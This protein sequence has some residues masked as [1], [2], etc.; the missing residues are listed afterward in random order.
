ME[1]RWQKV[2]TIV[3]LTGFFV[4]VGMSQALCAEKGPIKIGYISPTTGNFAQFG[5][6]MYDGFT[7]F[8]DEIKYQVAGRKIEL[9]REE[10]GTPATAVTKARKLITSDKINILAGVWLTPSAYAVAPVVEEAGIPF[11]VTSSGGDDLTQR[12]RSDT[13]I[14]LTYT[15]CHL[16]HALGHF[17][18]HKLGWRT[19]VVVGFDYAFAHE[20]VGAFHEVFEDQGGKILQKIWTPTD[21]MDFNPYVQSLNPEADGILDGVF[22]SSS[23]RFLRALKVAGK[24]Q[25]THQIAAAGTAVDETLLPALGDL[26][27]GIYSSYNWSAALQTPQNNKFVERTHEFLKREAS[28]G[29]SSNYTGADWI[30]RAIKAVDGDVENKSK[31]MKTLKA[32]EIED[33]PRG[34]VRLGKYNHNIQN[35]YIRRVDRRADVDPVIK[36]PGNFQETQNTVVYTYPSVSQFWTYDPEK[37]MARPIYSRDNPPCKFC[38]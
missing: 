12:K 15:G 28:V 18:Y 27:L 32:I 20:V 4:A 8:L 35:I 25:K 33:S 7:M 38:K 19:A 36:V 2:F 3:F 6:D 11:V 31:F 16:G 21:T 13:L 24:Y 17:A 1:I 30:V 5:R 37:Y 22:G 9:I 23:V 14:R 26:P 29:I 34:P 10:E